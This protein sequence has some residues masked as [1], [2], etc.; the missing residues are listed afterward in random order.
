VILAGGLNSRMGG[1]NK[2][3]LEVEGR[4]I[5]ERIIEAIDGLFSETLLVTRQ[6]DPYN[7]WPVTV[8]GDLFQN[9]ASLTG[10]HAG[11]A[12]CRSPYAFVLPCD[13]PFIRR[14]LIKLLLTEISAE[15]DVIVPHYNDRLQ[16]LCAIYSKRCIGPIEDQLTRGDMRIIDFFDRINLRIVPSERLRQA[17]PEMRSF[18]NVNT[19][20]ALKKCGAATATAP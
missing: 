20:E 2:A 11:L 19:L 12:Q 9:R 15:L 6:P 3:F 4:P 7:G 1:R 18:I 10:I 14:A 5:L 17:D 8:V 16:P 13:A